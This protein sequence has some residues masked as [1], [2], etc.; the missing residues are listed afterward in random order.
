MNRRDEDRIQDERDRADDELLGELDRAERDAWNDGRAEHQLLI[1][2]WE[3]NEIT[4]PLPID[5]RDRR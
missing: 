3:R 4:E 5:Y 2:E 1:E